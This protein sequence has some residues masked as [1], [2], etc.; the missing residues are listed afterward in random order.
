[1]IRIAILFRS[2]KAISNLFSKSK[3]K[4][5]RKHSRGSLTRIRHRKPPLPRSEDIAYRATCAVFSVTLSA[6]SNQ[7]EWKR[8]W[9]SAKRSTANRSGSVQRVSQGSKQAFFLPH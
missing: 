4:D 9:K 2:E 8:V 3:P 7:V 1:M 6:F 5:V